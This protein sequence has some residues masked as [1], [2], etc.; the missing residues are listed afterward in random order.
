MVNYFL[1]VKIKKKKHN[2]KTL[3]Q[4]GEKSVDFKVYI[5]NSL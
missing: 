3:G 2:L 4:S 1:F 5:K